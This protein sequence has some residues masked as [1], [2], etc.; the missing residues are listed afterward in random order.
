MLRS[1]SFVGPMR[2]PCNC[3]KPQETIPSR[4]Y[5]TRPQPR[6]SS[7]AALERAYAVED[8]RAAHTAIEFLN[9]ADLSGQTPTTRQLGLI[10]NCSHTSVRRAL[11]RFRKYTEEA[12]EEEQ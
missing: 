2:P 1:M 5:S 9:I 11:E 8:L 7:Y 6:N 10:L 4:V 3:S 12:R